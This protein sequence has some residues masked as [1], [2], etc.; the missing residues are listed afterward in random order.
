[1][2]G[3]LVFFGI[4]VLLMGLL[5]FAK[6]RPAP[7]AHNALPHMSSHVLKI[8]SPI[9]RQATVSL[10]GKAKLFW[11]NIKTETQRPN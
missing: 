7:S 4:F 1:M 8:S 10:K 6:T 5:I 11:R 2:K 3:I 9:A